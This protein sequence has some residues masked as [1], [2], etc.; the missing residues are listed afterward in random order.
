MGKRT[1]DKWLD[2]Y[3]L[4]KSLFYLMEKLWDTHKKESLIRTT[5]VALRNPIVFDNNVKDARHLLPYRCDLDSNNLVLDHLI[6]ISN[7]VLY[8]YDKKLYYKWDS[9]E[10]FKRTLRCLQVLLLVPKQL[11]NS[12]GFKT[13]Q[14]D[15]DD[16]G[17]CIYWN[18]KLQSNGITYLISEE[19]DE[20]S[21]ES[22][23]IKWY[24]ENQELLA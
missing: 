22:I 24:E 7:I 17:E 6:G 3:I 12:K 20:V 18:K 21:V 8:I 1:D 23:W 5:A 10:D 11:N 14:F 9:V 19:D 2:Y 13:W 16:I 4:T 15:L